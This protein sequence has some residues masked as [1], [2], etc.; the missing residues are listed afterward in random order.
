MSSKRTILVVDDDQPILLL[1]E[2]LLREFGFSA[3]TA[4]CGEDAIEAAR[5]EI[6]AAILLDMNMPGMCGEDVIAEFR[7]DPSLA[8]VPVI[9]LSGEKMSESEVKAFDA[10]AAVQKPFELSELI[11][12]IRESVDASEVSS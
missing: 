9:I 3:R 10:Y 4:S 7:K 6:P 5:Q 1:M 12:I 8:G 2:N 11:R